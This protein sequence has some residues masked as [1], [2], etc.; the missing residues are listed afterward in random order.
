MARIIALLF[1]CLFCVGCPT[2]IEIICSGA[3]N[4]LEVF[5]PTPWPTA[6]SQG[7][8]GW[9]TANPSV[10]GQTIAD[11]S[12]VVD[13]RWPTLRIPTLSAHWFSDLTTYH[14]VGQSHADW[15]I[16]VA[17]SNDAEF[18]D[19]YAS[20]ITVTPAQVVYLMAVF[21]GYAEQMGTKCLVT[22]VNL[23]PRFATRPAA[24]TFVNLQNS[25]IRTQFRNALAC[26]GSPRGD[27]C[28]IVD[29]TSGFSDPTLYIDDV[30][31][32]QA[33]ADQRAAAVRAALVNLP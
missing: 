21:C 30:H 9:M 33:G 25:L 11:F 17:E 7:P 22:T 5:L 26:A 14:R 15:V 28:R 16:L 2:N 13:P 8:W 3:S 24:T 23:P 31:L 29:F 6:L 20:Q 27:E 19:T 10:N 12:S 4:T 1:A 18:A 32:T